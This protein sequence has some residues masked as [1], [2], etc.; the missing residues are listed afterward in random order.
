[1][2]WEI[3]GNQVDLGAF[4]SGCLTKGTSLEDRGM[5]PLDTIPA[6]SVVLRPYP[7][8]PETEVKTRV[9]AWCSAWSSINGQFISTPAGNRN[10][11]PDPDGG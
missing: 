11:R 10:R 7:T 2:T 3:A 1:M 5:K 9:F 6:N 8:S 4:V